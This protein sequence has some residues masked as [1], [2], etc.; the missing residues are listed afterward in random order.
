MF[1]L[2]IITLFIGAGFIGGYLQIVHSKWHKNLFIGL[3]LIIISYVRAT[4]LII[5]AKSSQISLHEYQ[6][7]YGICYLFAIIGCFYLLPVMGGKGKK[8]KKPIKKGKL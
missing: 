4:S 2:S 1:S 5:S 7:I 6:N 3:F 8:E